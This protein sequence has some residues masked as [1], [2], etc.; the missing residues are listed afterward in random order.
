MGLTDCPW[1][2]VP[3]G[4]AGDLHCEG[5][6]LIQYTLT[7]KTWWAARCTGRAVTVN[8]L[9][10]WLHYHRRAR[11]PLSNCNEEGWLNNASKIHVSVCVNVCLRAWRTDSEKEQMS[12][13]TP[14]TS[15]SRHRTKQALLSCPLKLTLQ[16]TRKQRDRQTPYP[17]KQTHNQAENTE[18]DRHAGRQ[19]DRQAVVS[20]SVLLW[21]VPSSLPY[22]TEPRT[23]QKTERQADQA[24]NLIATTLALFVL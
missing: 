7:L 4:H 10:L 24:G 22:E 12:S 2:A 19:I 15:S 8:C 14:L 1:W 21:P 18:A 23:D 16:Q 20:P 3:L 17:I 11:R 9:M 13:M 5:D 6:G